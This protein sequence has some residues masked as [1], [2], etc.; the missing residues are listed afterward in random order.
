MLY[1]CLYKSGIQGFLIMISVVIVGYDVVSRFGLG[2]IHD[3]RESLLF[4]AH[5]RY[6]TVYLKPG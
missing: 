3:L 2:S 1:S 6:S 5:G 4:L